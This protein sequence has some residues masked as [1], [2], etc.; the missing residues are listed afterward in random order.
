M[1][2]ENLEKQEGSQSQ[3][4]KLLKKSAKETFQC[5]DDANA[6]LGKRKSNYMKLEFQIVVGMEVRRK[7]KSET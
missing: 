4:C 7:R 3:L 6:G 2:R 5:D 1:C